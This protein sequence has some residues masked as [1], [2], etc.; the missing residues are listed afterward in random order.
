MVYVE[1]GQ[2]ECHPFRTTGPREIHRLHRQVSL[3]QLRPRICKLADPALPRLCL[4][5]LI[6]R[7]E[8]IDLRN[9]RIAEDHPIHH[10]NNHSDMP[11]WSLLLAVLSTVLVAYR[12]LGSRLPG[13]RILLGDLRW[14]QHP[15]V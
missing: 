5:N 9:F 2:L 6:R 1:W 14:N 12:L 10:H 4:T 8:D 7:V 15:Y 3:A 11:P 13:K